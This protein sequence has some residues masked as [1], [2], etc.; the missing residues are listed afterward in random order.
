MGFLHEHIIWAFLFISD[1]YCH[2]CH[3]LLGFSKILGVLSFLVC[4]FNSS[5]GGGGAK[6]ATLPHFS[7]LR[8]SAVE[9]ESFFGLLH[10][11]Q[12]TN[13]EKATFKTF[14]IELFLQMF[15]MN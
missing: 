14:E 3:K 7:G 6:L 12:K 2:V 8:W 13:V 10:S 11:M 1:N 5:G 15:C 4:F 9:R